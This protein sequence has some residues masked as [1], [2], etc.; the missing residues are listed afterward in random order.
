MSDDIVAHY[1]LPSWPDRKPDFV[2]P[3]EILSNKVIL[4]NE[5]I[6]VS[7]LN[8][9]DHKTWRVSND[10]AIPCI[11]STEWAVITPKEGVDIDFLYALVTDVSFQ[12]QL[13]C[14][15]TGTSASHQRVRHKDLMS[16]NV[17]LFSKVNEQKIGRIINELRTINLELIGGSALILET[18]QVLFD[19]WIDGKLFSEYGKVDTEQWE[20]ASIL[21]IGEF[22]N[23]VAAQKYPPIDGEEALPV[24]KIREMQTGIDRGSNFASITTPEKYHI[25]DGDILF[26]WAATLLVKHWHGVNS[27]LNQHIFK[28]IPGDFPAWFVFYTLRKE[29]GKFIHMAKDGE[30]TMGHITRKQLQN[31]L[32]TLPPK[33]LIDSFTLIIEPLYLRSKSNISFSNSITE[34]MNSMLP[35]LISGQINPG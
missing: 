35:K 30:T 6:L 1:S 10:G 34:L 28:V 27:I 21:D 2:K 18:S 31:H 9:I 13:E 33:E 29:I 8:P 25:Q 32:I 11:G 3:Q 24:V 19:Y 26:S 20:K 12:V 22:I 14:F 16:I 23:G 5:C 4:P 7:R 15:A 17:N